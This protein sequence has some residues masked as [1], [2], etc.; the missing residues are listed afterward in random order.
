MH[1][2]CILHV[3]SYHV[4]IQDSSYFQVHRLNVKNREFHSSG[5]SHTKKQALETLGTA[6]LN[7]HSPLQA[8]LI[9]VGFLFLR[10]EFPCRTSCRH[11]MCCP[12]HVWLDICFT[13]VNT[14]CIAVEYSPTFHKK[15]Q[16]SKFSHIHHILIG[17]GPVPFPIIP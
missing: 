1:L 12:K 15:N 14:K 9:K 10:A 7:H 6:S 11:F 17:D 13:R 3:H 5:R 2:I 16:C 4:Q 8:G